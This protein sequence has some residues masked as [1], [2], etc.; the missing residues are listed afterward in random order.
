[1]KPKPKRFQLSAPRFF[2]GR[3]AQIAG[4]MS[5]QVYEGQSSNE[6]VLQNTP[7]LLALYAFLARPVP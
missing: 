1:M 3:T 5:R 4:Q 6:R 2:T 7:S